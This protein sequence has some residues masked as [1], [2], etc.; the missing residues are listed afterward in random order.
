MNGCAHRDHHR[1]GCRD[2]ILRIVKFPPPLMPYRFHLN[3]NARWHRRRGHLEE[4]AN[5]KDEH[6]DKKDGRGNRPGYFNGGIAMNLSRCRI[7]WSSAITNNKEDQDTLYYY[8]NDGGN[9]QDRP[10]HPAL[11]GRD[12]PG[13]IQDRGRVPLT[14]GN[15]QY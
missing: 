4:A 9:D 14:T 10:E 12:R 13:G 2:M 5:G 6:N 1:V 3:R 7:S 15:K 11:A 8:K